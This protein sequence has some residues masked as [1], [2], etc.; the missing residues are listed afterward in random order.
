[1]NIRAFSIFLLFTKVNTV[2]SAASTQCE[3][4]T[5]Y[6]KLDN[7]PKSCDMVKND[8][9]LCAKGGGVSGYVINHCPAT[10]GV[11]DCSAI[12]SDMRFPVLLEK[13]FGSGD[14]KNVWKQCNPWVSKDPDIACNKCEKEGVRG[15]C[16][17]TCSESCTV[18]SAPTPTPGP[19]CQDSPLPFRFLEKLYNCDIV[20]NAPTDFCGLSGDIPGDINTHC[21]VACG[22]SDCTNKETNMY[23]QV[24]ADG[25]LKF[26]QCDPWVMANDEMHCAN[27]C[28][29]SEVA[30]TCPV[31]CARC[32]V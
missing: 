29:R 13:P 21:P 6:F 15:T 22:V 28:G 23:F 27:R 3:D 4:S 8:L 18:T 9:S 5:L 20:K 31:S 30:K 14:Y 26:K 17:V 19:S 12:E 32:P 24:M 2:S 10:C 7:V 16:P 1:M 25:N 11:T